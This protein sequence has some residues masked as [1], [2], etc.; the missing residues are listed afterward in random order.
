MIASRCFEGA[1]GAEGAELCTVQSEKSNEYLVW[2][3]FRRDV[4]GKAV[5]S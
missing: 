3:G 1:E 2:G 4:I 5:F